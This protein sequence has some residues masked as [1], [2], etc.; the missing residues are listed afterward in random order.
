VEYP[1]WFRRVLCVVGVRATGDRG[2]RGIVRAAGDF[3]DKAGRDVLLVAEAML[4]ESLGLA[5]RAAYMMKV[6]RSN[7]GV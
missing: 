6:V 1:L 5:R 4:R 2:V 3:S 7:Q